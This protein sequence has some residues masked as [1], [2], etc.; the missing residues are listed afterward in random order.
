MWSKIGWRME[1][2]YAGMGEYANT[3]KCRQLIPVLHLHRVFFAI[4]VVLGHWWNDG[5]YFYRQTVKL[6]LSHNHWLIFIVNKN[7]FWDSKFA[8]LFAILNQCKQQTTS[9]WDSSKEKLI[10]IILDDFL[11]RLDSAKMSEIDVEHRESELSFT[12]LFSEKAW[13]D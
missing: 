7:A 13:V 1:F 8:K 12:C 4:L 11:F 6:N 3:T 10:K 9:K 5:V 2:N